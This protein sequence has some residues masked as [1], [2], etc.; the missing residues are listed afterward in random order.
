MVW[1]TKYLAGGPR[2]RSGTTGPPCG[3]PERTASRRRG[4]DRAAE[5]PRKLGTDPEGG[6]LVLLGGC[7]KRTGATATRPPP[8]VCLGDWEAQGH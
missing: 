5:G 3:C 6:K 2:W 1:I 8:R 4:C 7:R